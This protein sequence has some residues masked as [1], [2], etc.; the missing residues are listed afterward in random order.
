MTWDALPQWRGFSIDPQ[1][2]YRQP[3]LPYDPWDFDFTAEQGFNFVRLPADY[4]R[5]TPTP[6]AT[7]EAPLRQIDQAIAL[8]RERKIHANL[9]LFDAPGYDH[10]SR[11]MIL[12]LWGASASGEEARRRFA[13]VWRGLAARYKGIPS[14]E[15]SFNLLNEPPDISAEAYTRVVEPV[16][17]AIRA[18]DPG[19]LLIADGRYW[20]QKPMPELA[21]LEVAQSTHQYEPQHLTHYKASWVEGSDKWPVPTWPLL[22]APNPFIYGSFQKQFQSPLVLRG[23]FPAG[24]EVR[25]T[26]D[27]V[28]HGADLT[29]RADGKAILQRS[30]AA[31]AGAGEWKSSTFRPQYNDYLATYDKPYAA[32]LTSGAR[33]LAFEVTAGDWI[34]FSE[35]RV[36]PW[37]NGDLII[38]PGLR[39]SGV[40]QDTYTIDASGAALPQNGHATTKDD[41]WRENIAP[42][43]QL[44]STGV[45]VHV[46]EWGAHNLTPHDVVLRW[47]ADQLELFKRAGWGWALW[48]LRGSFGPVD[49]ER[50]DVKYEDYKGHKLDRAMLELLKRG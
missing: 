2:P 5:W 25:I 46:G 22:P 35:I 24:G 31:G 9:A 39:L 41:L 3:P 50:K 49:S 33:E 8:A 6:G 44:E 32:T 27:Q 7:D 14:A 1:A 34:T 29:V 18:E 17:A 26:V 12:D 37:T 20:G 43:K 40:R 38:R 36:R 13:D 45:G 11:P 30:L 48:N 47:M 4:R 28:S 19:R 21:R 10:F 16:V 42:W 15:L 23:E